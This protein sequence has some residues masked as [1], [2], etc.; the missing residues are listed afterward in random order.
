M[1][2]V[3]NLRTIDQDSWSR[4]QQFHHYRRRVPCTYAITVEVDVT[5]AT[6]VLRGSRWKTYPTQIWAIASLVN[7]HE[8]FRLALDDQ[9][10]PA[11]WDEL[12]PSFTVFN[13][14]RETFAAVWV[15][16]DADF[17]SFHERAV[18]VLATHRGATDMFPQGDLPANA[19]DI[20]SLPWTTFTGFTLQIDGGWDHFL[21][22][23]TLGRYVQRDGRTLL[24]VALQ[25]HHAA[26]DGFHT[27]RLMQELEDLM[28][29]PDWIS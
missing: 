18:E 25:M 14:E 12:H 26:A 4:R 2:L 7:R 20:S 19:F 17:P 22:I 28:S 27:A 21:P 1:L 29:A 24:P 3:S 8:E 10:A 15:P 13:P 6:D 5:A 16:F 23:F 9:G 11:V